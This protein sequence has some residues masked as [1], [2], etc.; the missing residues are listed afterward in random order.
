MKDII[1]L[2]IGATIGFIFS[3]LTM[4]IEPIVKKYINPKIEK[5]IKTYKQ[6][7]EQRKMKRQI[8]A[9]KNDIKKLRKI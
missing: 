8:I 7:S 4:I 9:L 5:R 3:I 6:K 2:F 1:L